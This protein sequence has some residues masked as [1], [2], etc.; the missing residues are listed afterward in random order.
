MIHR[1]GSVLDGNEALASL[2]GV[3]EN[4]L[5]GQHLG[6]IVP[7]GATPF[8][9]A[10]RSSTRGESEIV[11][12]TGQR[13]PIEMLSRTIP[14]RGSLATVT[15]L[16]DISERRDSEARI[17][18]LAHHD[19]LTAL[20]NRA[21][22]TEELENKLAAATEKS[23]TLA[24]LCLDLDGFKLVND[25]Y[26]HATGDELLRQVAARLRAAMREGEFVARIGGDEFVVL[27]SSGTQPG[28]AGDLAQRIIAALTSPFDP[29]GRRVTIGT[30]VGVAI[31]PRDGAEPNQL[32]KRADIALYRA[33]HNGRGCVRFFDAAVDHEVDD[34]PQLEQEL[35]DALAKGE[36][37]LAYQPIF[38][39]VGKL[40]S[41]EA[42][43][44]WTHPVLGPISPARFIPIAESRQLILPMGEW[45][46]REA[47]RTAAT[48]AGDIR[49][50]VNLSPVQVVQKDL[51]SR[52]DA[53]LRETGL[54]HERLE[55]EIT[56]GVLL[57]DEEAA[58][59]VI[60]ALGK[61]GVRIVLDDFGTG[62]SSLSYLHRFRFDKLKIDRSFIHRLLHERSAQ[63]IVKAIISM[64]RDL[65]M[66][67]TA[68]GVETTEQMEA[69]TAQS[70]HE[71][72][73]FLLGRPMPGEDA[74]R[75]ALEHGAE[76]GLREL[77]RLRTAMGGGR[78]EAVSAA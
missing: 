7:E 53:V 33:K 47:C 27:Q 24:V 54:S 62:Y 48:W 19:M 67:V 57:K 4:S 45:A 68:E 71:L 58:C 9:T 66:E 31:F 46:L 36:L 17:R 65:G 13:L 29:G 60:T 75:L 52:I 61:R 37:S 41:F 6:R 21:L 72:Q 42:L 1:D 15:A 22:L 73:G 74:N 5:A 34:R 69:L 12:A 28:K 26:G 49:V 40:V 56:E 44:R 32:V 10:N 43:M 2:L 11:T 20:P 59:D 70:C 77:E 64:S 76:G 39:C 63:A 38:D 78:T 18:F 8:W 23:D 3:R 14:Y 16:R 55:L 35:R 51:L 25:T 50:A 30:S